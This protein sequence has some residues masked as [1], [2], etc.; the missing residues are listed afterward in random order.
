M[1][2]QEKAETYDWGTFGK[3]MDP[4]N[5]QRKLLKDLTTN[6]LCAILTTELHIRMTDYI[7]VI[8][9]IL[10]DRSRNNTHFFD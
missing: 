1:T 8:A 6:H 10:E 7:E 9:Y 3:P 2:I 5:Y 4:K